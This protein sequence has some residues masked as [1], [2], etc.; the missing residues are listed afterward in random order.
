MIQDVE[1]MSAPRYK[2]W[3]LVF[4]LVERLY[5]ADNLN[6]AGDID[7]KEKGNITLIRS[8]HNAVTGL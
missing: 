3:G 5:P 1:H 7:Y 8:C 4:C 6:R 2:I